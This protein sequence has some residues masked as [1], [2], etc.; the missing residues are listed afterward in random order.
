MLSILLPGQFSLEISDVL[1]YL[2][3][4]SLSLSLSVVNF[5]LAVLSGE[6]ERLWNV[7]RADSL[8]FNAWTSLIEETEKVAEVCKVDFGC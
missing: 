2:F 7:V 5:L 3:S 4:L 8:D 1:C 6:E